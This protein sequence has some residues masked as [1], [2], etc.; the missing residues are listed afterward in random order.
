MSHHLQGI[1]DRLTLAIESPSLHSLSHD[2][3]CR[4][5][6]QVVDIVQGMGAIQRAIQRAMGPATEDAERHVDPHC[7]R[8]VSREPERWIL[9]T[10]PWPRVLSGLRVPA[11]CKAWPRWHLR[12]AKFF[13]MH[14]EAAFSARTDGIVRDSNLL[15]RFPGQAYAF[16]GSSCFFHSEQSDFASDNAHSHS[17]LYSSGARRQ[18]IVNVRLESKLRL[19]LLRSAVKC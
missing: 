17:T 15:V 11:Q 6:P 13:P 10:D 3:T 7:P 19:R 2:M 18:Q 4:T 9:C 8:G 16:G 14:G 12:C 1:L 5:H